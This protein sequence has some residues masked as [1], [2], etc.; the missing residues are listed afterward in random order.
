MKQQL[1]AFTYPQRVV[2]PLTTEAEGDLSLCPRAVG[3]LLVRVQ[4]ARGLPGLGVTHSF[5]PYV[6]LR[7][8]GMPTTAEGPHRL[9]TRSPEWV[10]CVNSF[11]WM[12]RLYLT[13]RC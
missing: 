12:H 5:S 7:V 10:R 6:K 1:A 13:V 11:P 8:A 3:C 4:R 9:L 2:I